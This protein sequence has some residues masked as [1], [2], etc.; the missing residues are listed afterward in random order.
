M[1]LLAFS[2]TGPLFGGTVDDFGVCVNVYEIMLMCARTHM[3]PQI[4]A[5]GERKALA[6]KMH[7]HTHTETHTDGYYVQPGGARNL[8]FLVPKS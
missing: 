6:K 4:N 3:S 1:R 5:D 7:T 2:G 8:L